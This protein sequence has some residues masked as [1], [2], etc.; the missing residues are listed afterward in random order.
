MYITPD[1]IVNAD[2]MEVLP[3][4]PDGKFDAVISDPPYQFEA[5]DRGFSGKR[6]IY[7][8][9]AQWTNMDNDWYNE[10]IL[11][12]YV[13]ICKFPNI[14]LFGGKRDVYKMLKF[15]VENNL[16]YWI[17]PVCKKAPA[18]FTNNTWLTSEFAVHIVDRRLDYT[19]E[20]N[21][22]I[23]YFIVGGQKTTGHP[24]EKD[25]PMVKR[26]VANITREGDFVFDGF[27]GSGTTAVACQQLKRNFF[28]C[29]LN[30]E[31]YEKTLKRLDDEK[32]QLNLF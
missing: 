17:I 19:K 5:H 18:P 25:L 12:E 13:R 32:R 22:K 7:K 4:I 8:E 3:Q 24:N 11:K 27:M 20:Y 15:A 21:L 1:T 14:F 26:I 23:P 28:G 16:E 30:K 2:I 9:M 29:E 6:T 10:D 31:Y